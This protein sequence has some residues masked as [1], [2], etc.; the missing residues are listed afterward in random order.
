MANKQRTVAI[1]GLGTFGKAVARELTRVGDRVLG[2]DINPKRVSDLADELDA[3]IQADTT[4]IKALK[5]CGFESFDT[6]VVAIGREMEAS[7][8]TALNAIELGRSKVWVKSQSF[9][10][11]KILKAIGVT[12][13][14]QPEGEYG[15]RLAHMIHNP[16]VKDFLSL[17]S[18]AYIVKM[19]VPHNL[20]GRQLSELNL[21]KKFSVTC[22]GI[23]SGSDVGVENCNDA[24]LE[25]GQHLLILGRRPD[26]RRF[27]DS[28]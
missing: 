3:T 17:S 21:Q 15:Y 11:T 14:I 5:Q 24:I 9:T 27:A 25:N 4:D 10:H 28:L 18:D 2:I 19:V 13:I 20:I 7:V 26:I 16:L 8:L 22:I 1:I 12:N 23:A 6:V